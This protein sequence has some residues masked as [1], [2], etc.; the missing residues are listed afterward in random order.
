MPR[1]FTFPVLYDEA[2]QLTTTKL[3]QWGYLN[4]KEIK[5]GRIFWNSHRNQTGSISIKVNTINEQPYIEFNYK[6]RDEPRIYKVG[7][8]SLFSNL[9]KGVIWYFLCPVTNKRC[10]KLYLVDGY[11]LHREAF[12]GCMYKSQA[13]TKEKGF[14]RYFKNQIKLDDLNEKIYSKHFK[15]HY[16]GKPTKRYLRIMEKI[17]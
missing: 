9:G 11:F 15:R 17:D 12:K 8:V 16:A 7:F 4:S 6:Y 3:K 13:K 10:R 14:F 2:L 1:P 5:S